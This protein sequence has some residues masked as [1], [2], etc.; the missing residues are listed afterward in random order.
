MKGIVLAGGKGTRLYP[1]T[2]AVSKQILPLYDKPMIYYSISTLLL[3]GIK[4]I[5]IISTP[6]DLPMFKE[7]LGDGSRIGVKFEYAE[8][9]EARGLAE[10]FVIGEDFIGD[11]DV[12]LILGDNIFFGNGMTTILNE[13]QKNL[14][15]AVIF[16]YQ[17]ADPKSYGVVEFDESGH[18]LS[19]EEKPDNPKSNY[20]IPGLYFF[21]NDVINISKQVQPSGRGELEITSI[22][23][24][25][26]KQHKLDVKIL[27][28]G[29]AWLDT[30]T[31]KNL[32]EASSFVQTVQTRQ[33][34]YVGCLEEIAYRRGF[35]D[36]EQLLTL[37]QE[38]HKTDYGQYLISLAK[39]V[40]Q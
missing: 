25:Y 5:L 2:K 8:Q 27:P 14:D 29:I 34:L 1:M 17:V 33:N 12:C 3:A 38:L 21:N 28:R 35:I 9:K 36:A 39:G 31:T 11:D 30:G 13:A 18:V 10:A 32:L 22:N 37:G 40:I 16:G 19:L 23:I 24:E 6:R 4:E 20:A 7:L 15:G 26:M